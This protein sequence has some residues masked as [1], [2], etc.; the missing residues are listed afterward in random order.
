M[1]GVKVVYTRKDDR[2]VELDRRG[3]IANEAGG[4]LFISIHANSLK[5]KPHPTR[6]FEVYLL[7]PGRTEEAIAIAE[8]ENAVIELEEGYENRYKELTDENFILV[9]MAQT[10][11]MRAS[12]IFADI[13]QKELESNTGLQNRGVK[14]AGFYVLVGASMPNV[15]LETAYLSN[16]QD[17]RFLKSESGQQKVA[18]A[19]FGSIKRYKEEYEKQLNEG[20]DIGQR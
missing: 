8:R 3:Q 5:Q 14:Q 17:E 9:T 11:H 7:R 13:A 19:L 15:L 10:A 16:K 18:D 2:F 6:G 4:K 12:E 1:K 20:K